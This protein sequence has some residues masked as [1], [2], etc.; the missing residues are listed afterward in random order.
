MSRSTTTTRALSRYRPDPTQADRPWLLAIVDQT[1]TRTLVSELE[2][3]LLKSFRVA[4]CPTVTAGA[5]LI[6]ACNEAGDPVAVVLSEEP[7]AGMSGGGLWGLQ[8]C[9]SLRPE[10]VRLLGVHHADSL[11][12]VSID[13]LRDADVHQVFSLNTPPDLFIQQILGPLTAKTEDGI[14]ESLRSATVRAT[15]PVKLLKIPKETFWE[16]LLHD[17]RLSLGITREL[18]R[19]LRKLQS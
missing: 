7:L 9:R 12:K 4:I 11:L 1:E 10:A 14:D 17:S 8:K 18:A 16:L 2:Q 15:S 19:R 3:R 6:E 5:K 13:K